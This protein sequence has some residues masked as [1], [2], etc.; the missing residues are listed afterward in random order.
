[1]RDFFIF[2]FCLIAALAIVW[3]VFPGRSRTTTGF[4]C[5]APDGWAF[6]TCKDADG[7]RKWTI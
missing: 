2:A 6:N 4:S 3:T 7:D 5:Y 1:M